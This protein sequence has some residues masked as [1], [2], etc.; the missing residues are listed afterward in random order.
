MFF[1]RKKNSDEHR[2]DLL[3]GQ[4]RGNRRKRKQQFFWAC[5]AGAFFAILVG[6]A[7]WLVNNPPR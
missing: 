5:I 3:P 6:A 1:R 4:G 2:Y 7:I